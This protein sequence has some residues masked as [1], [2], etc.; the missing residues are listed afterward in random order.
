MRFAAATNNT[1]L[2]TRL[3]EKGVS[4]NNHDDQGRSPLHLASCRYNINN[5]KINNVFRIK[6][7][8]IKI[9]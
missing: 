3:L 6:I 1:E 4:P 9:F 7:F 2:L 8:K 5:N